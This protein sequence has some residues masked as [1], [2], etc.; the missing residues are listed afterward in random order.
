MWNEAGCWDDDDDDDGGGGGG[1]V[2][3]AE[4][5]QAELGTL[6][7]RSTRVDLCR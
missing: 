7:R 6:E 5:R 4:S 1:D 2:G 3:R